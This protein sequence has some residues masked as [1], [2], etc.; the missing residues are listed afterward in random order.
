MR[1]RLY[2]PVGGAGPEPP[3]HPHARADRTDPDRPGDH[4]AVTDRAAADR[5]GIVAVAIQAQPKTEG[6]RVAFFR[7]SDLTLL[8]HVAVGA[9]PDMITFTPDGRRVLT[10]N[11]AEPTKRVAPERATKMPATSQFFRCA[12]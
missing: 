11:E 10:A 1:Y 6:G 7:A 4:G 3:A 9:Q 5:G 12:A 8:S 2:R